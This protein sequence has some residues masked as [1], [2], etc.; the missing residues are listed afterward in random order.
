MEIR[1]EIRVEI[2]GFQ[3]NLF[4]AG[5]YLGLTRLDLNEIKNTFLRRLLGFFE[6]ETIILIYKNSILGLTIAVCMVIFG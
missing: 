3:S 2:F 1:V 4:N 5:W 6:P